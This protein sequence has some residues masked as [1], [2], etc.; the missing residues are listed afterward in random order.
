MGIL[1]VDVLIWLCGGGAKMM[2]GPWERCCL[3]C[4][5]VAALLPLS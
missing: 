1:I 5:C 2:P 4:V 3:A